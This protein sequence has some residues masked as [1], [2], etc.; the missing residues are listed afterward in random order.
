M[1]GGC[2]GL[3]TRHDETSK[4][5]FSEA[6]LVLFGPVLWPRYASQVR[7]P[8]PNRKLLA[9]LS[10]DVEESFISSWLEDVGVLAAAFALYV[11]FQGLR[12][13]N[14]DAKSKLG[15]R[16]ERPSQRIL[17]NCRRGSS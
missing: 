9:T 13:S 1:V 15:K 7:Y 17:S 12:E 4:S 16:G 8:N 2:G 5:W 6:G 14:S 3:T 11:S 10:G